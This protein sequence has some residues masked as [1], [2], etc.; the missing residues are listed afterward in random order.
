MLRLR[1]RS[2]G[3]FVKLDNVIRFEDDVLVVVLEFVE[4]LLG[5]AT[6]R[7]SVLCL[8]KSNVLVFKFLLCYKRAN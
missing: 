2:R 8:V 3:L 7:R 5:G 6:T 4:C 1:E